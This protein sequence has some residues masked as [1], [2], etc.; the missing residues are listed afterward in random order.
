MKKIEY[1]NWSTDIFQGFYE[2]GLYDNDKLYYISQEEDKEYDFVNGGWTNFTETVARKVVDLLNDYCRG[3]LIKKITFKELF[4]PRFYNFDTDRLILTV[5]CDW[6]GLV[7]YCYETSADFDKY[8]HDN[9]TSRSGFMSFV[10][11]NITDFMNQLDDDFEKLSQVVIEYY[12][13]NRIDDIDEYQL[14][15]SEIASNELWNNIAPVEQ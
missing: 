6:K 5:D 1:M 12:L 9:F 14:E 13:L 15:S 11:N 7:D 2:S 8:L 4:S 10:P 3:G